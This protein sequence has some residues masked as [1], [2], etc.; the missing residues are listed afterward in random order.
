VL[1]IYCLRADS[2]GEKS[3]VPLAKLGFN[4][5]LFYEVCKSREK[6]FD[7]SLDKDIV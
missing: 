3:R 5:C 2:I 6:I 4:A 7:L 1:K